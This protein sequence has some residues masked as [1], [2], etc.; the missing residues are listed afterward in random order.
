MTVRVQEE[1]VKLERQHS[2]SREERRVER[3]GTKMPK[4][5]AAHE[6][7]T[8]SIRSKQT[9]TR[10]DFVHT[11]PHLRGV[12]VVRLEVL[13]GALEQQVAGGREH[14]HVAA[15][16]E[17]SPPR[18]SPRNG[19]FCQFA[20][21]GV[22]ALAV[23]LEGRDDHREKVKLRGEVRDTCTPRLPQVRLDRFLIA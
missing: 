7:R 14:H 16:L 12:F 11:C 1:G 22:L 3:K 10:Q 2:R 5:H 19:A 18:T 8:G 17:R 6:G 13:R 23:L 9:K 20:L 15:L 21:L 4:Q